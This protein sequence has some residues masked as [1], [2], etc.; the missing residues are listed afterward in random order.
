MER[1]TPPPG[2]ADFR[3]GGEGNVA[4]NV[5]RFSTLPVLI[6]SPVIWQIKPTV[7]QGMSFRTCIAEK[8]A[9][10]TVLNHSSPAAVLRHNPD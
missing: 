10:L 4:G 2:D 3:L 6:I 1:T 9:D 5:V 8:N 7:N